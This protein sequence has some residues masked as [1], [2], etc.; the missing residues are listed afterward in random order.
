[1]MSRRGTV[2]RNVVKHVFVWSWPFS[3][4]T[5]LRDNWFPKR[6]IPTSTLRNRQTTAEYRYQSD[7]L[8]IIVV[9]HFHNHALLIP[10]NMSSVVINV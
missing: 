4:I 5:I 7:F 2:Y 6:F 3:S 1:M 8:E 10:Y 9:P